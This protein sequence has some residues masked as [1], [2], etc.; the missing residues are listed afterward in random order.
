MRKLELLKQ[1]MDP[2]DSWRP[3][4]VTGADILRKYLT[5]LVGVISAH[6]RYAVIKRAASITMTCASV[7]TLVIV[8]IGPK[9]NVSLDD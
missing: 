8:R 4:I 9:Y 1:E 3:T 7:C 5:I 6:Y 2:D